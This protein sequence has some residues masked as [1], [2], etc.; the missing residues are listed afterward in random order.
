MST[1][2]NLA[3]LLSATVIPACWVVT[4]LW[5]PAETGVFEIYPFRVVC[6][7]AVI[8][9]AS[10]AITYI[11]LAETKATRWLRVR[12]LAVLVGSLTVC[13]LLLELPAVFGLD[14]RKFFPHPWQPPF[15]RDLRP[16]PELIWIHKPYLTFSGKFVGGLVNW[17][18]IETDRRYDLD[19]RYDR[20]GFRNPIDLDQADVVIL[21]DSFAESSWVVYDDIVSARL[22]KALGTRVLNLGHNGYGPQ[23]ELVV[24]KRFGIS[25]QPKIV[26]WLFY[27]GNDLQ[28]Y[29]RYEEIRADW[30]QFISKDN[31]FANRS[32]SRTVLKALARMLSSKRPTPE[33][34]QL[35]EGAYGTLTAG[36]GAGE[37]MYFYFRPRPLPDKAKAALD[38]AK[39]AIHN[40]F[41]I[42]AENQVRFLLVF[43][44]AK[45]RVYKDLVE[46]PPSTQLDPRQTNDLPEEMRDWC[47]VRAIPYLDLTPILTRAAKENSDLIYFLDDEHWTSKGNEVVA[48]QILGLLRQLGGGP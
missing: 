6:I 46:L 8:T 37:R 17:F 35:G 24:L 9:L 12:R 30:N 39:Q 2:R 32:F 34:R 7:N 11:A 31:T 21:G 20:N 42:C 48:Q 13:V 28:D 36:E 33:A 45:Y 22:G 10:L 1:R 47:S 29:V 40:G 3:L 5:F 18:G 4:A 14:Y 19:V 27:E 23:Q 43:V 38:G 16:D 25:V 26:V 44:P 41:R 15:E